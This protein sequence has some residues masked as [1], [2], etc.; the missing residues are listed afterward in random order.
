[1][2]L[3]FPSIAPSVFPLIEDWEDIGIS[4]GFED[5]TEQSRP[6]FTRSRGTW[7]LHW[8]ALPDADY[9]TLI[10]FWRDEAKGCSNSFVWTHPISK[11]DMVVRFVE[12]KEFQ[13]NAPSFWSGE[14]TLKEV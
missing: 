14:I 6:R 13:K 4:A 2:P 5:G 3:F 7:T 11:K 12:K 8:T 9:Q 10:K 1:M